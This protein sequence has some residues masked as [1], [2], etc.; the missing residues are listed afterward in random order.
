MNGKEFLKRLFKTGDATDE[1]IS[2]FMLK[3]YF[4]KGYGLDD[5]YDDLIFKYNKPEEYCK[6]VRDCFE[7]VLKKYSR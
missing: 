3:Y 6:A 1:E 2:K 4:L 7:D 5:F